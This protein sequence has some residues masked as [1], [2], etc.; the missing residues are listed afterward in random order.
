MIEVIADTHVLQIFLPL[1]LLFEVPANE[2]GLLPH[3][4]QVILLFPFLFDTSGWDW[5]IG[6]RNEII[7][8]IAGSLLSFAAC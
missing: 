3:L 1:L 4:L 5:L 7:W 6:I 8:I 2:N